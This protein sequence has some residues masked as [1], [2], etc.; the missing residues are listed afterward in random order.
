MNGWRAVRAVALR[1]LRAE[2]RG[3]E[4]IPAMTQFVVLALIIANFAF[5]LDRVSAPR[6][7]P[8]VLWMVIVFTALIAFGRAFAADRENG[9]LDA[10]LLSPAGA[11]AIFLGK[12]LAAVVFMLVIEAFLLP[13]MAVFLGSPINLEVVAAV[14]LATLG[15]AA[16]GSLFA[17]L[18]ARTRAREILLP[19]LVL[20]LWI[21][22][23][24]VGSRAV[25]EAM[26][27]GALQGQPLPLLLDF[28]ILFV[29]VA[30]LAA[31][32]VLDD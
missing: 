11:A 25:E 6:I 29:V 21:P 13:G 16:L 7:S 18:A 4:L 2:T 17:A 5:D 1:D 26:G 14:V 23:I 15:M 31:R 3:G 12:A 8:G 20:P 30:T 24:V 28:D 10:M 27:G 22:L 32:F 9:S 19:V